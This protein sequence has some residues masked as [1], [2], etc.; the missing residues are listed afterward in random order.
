MRN[1]VVIGGGLAG[2][3]AAW[4]AAKLGCSVTLFE[5]RPHQQTG[6]HLTDSLAEVVCS[7]SFGSTQPD[8]AQGHLKTELK[9]LGSLLLEC[10]KATALPAGGALA[11]DRTA[12]SALVTE[13]ISACSNIKI[14]RQEIT[15]IPASP[16]IIASG[17]LTSPALAKAVG[18]F[19]SA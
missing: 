11:V 8:R 1:L 15:Q 17:P 16:A 13:K 14:I 7:N 19:T 5:M 12:F 9:I 3:E 2:T 10:A 18:E 4:Q 6:A